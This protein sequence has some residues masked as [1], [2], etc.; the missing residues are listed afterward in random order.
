TPMA[1]VLIYTSTSDADGTLGGLQRQGEY[2][3]LAGII[4]DAPIAANRWLCDQLCITDVLGG[5]DFLTLAACDACSMAPE[6]S[7]ELFNRFL[8]RGVMLGVPD[9]PGYFQPLMED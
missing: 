9:C 1:G 6:T 7:C 8:D 5:T 4:T 3:R 2:A